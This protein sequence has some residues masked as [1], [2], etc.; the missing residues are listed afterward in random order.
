MGRVGPQATVSELS[1]ICDINRDSLMELMSQHM[2]SQIDRAVA[3]TSS[4]QVYVINSRGLVQLGSSLGSVFLLFPM[5]V[6]R[7]HAHSNL[8]KSPAPGS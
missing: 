8:G 4:C 7:A 6:A 3:K 2:D 1:L 5:K